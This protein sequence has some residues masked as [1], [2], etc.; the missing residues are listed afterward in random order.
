M[1]SLIEAIKNRMIFCDGGM[2]TL[3]QQ[4]GLTAGEQ[5]E[6]WNIDNRQSI[7]NIH[8]DYLKAGA[9]IITTDTFGANRLKFPD[10]G[11]YSVENVVAA[12]VGN[13]R[14]A[15]EAFGAS[16][17]YVALDIGPTGKLL[18]PAGDLDFEEA[19][20]VFAQ[21]VRQ[22][23]KSGV[24]LILIETMSDSLEARAAVLAAK[25]SCDLPVF[26]SLIFGENGKLLTGGSPASAIT[27]LEALGV[28]AVGMNCGTGPE[29]MKA[30]LPELLA[31]ATVPVIVNPN[32]GI[33]HT[34]NGKTVFDVTPDKFSVVMREIAEMG[35]NIIGG[36]CGTTPEHI[37]E[38]VKLCKSIT[39]K[40][41]ARHIKSVISSST[42]V[43]E[44]GE[45]PIIIG[46]R[47]N[48][49]GK[50]KFKQALRDN[51]VEYIF[52]EAIRQRDS[53]ADVLD[54]NVGLP[55]I[56]EPKMM[57]TI[58]SQLQAI[59]DLPLQIDT[60]DA[61]AMEKALRVYN[62]KAIINSVNGKAESLRTVLPLVKKYGG[63]A[64]ALLLDENGIPDTAEGRME[65]ARRILRAAEEN[66]IDRRD[67][68]FDALTLTIS[69]D[70]KGAL[71]TLETVGRIKNELGCHTVLGVSNVSFGLPQREIINSTFFALALQRG[72]S[73]AIIN[74]L[75]S[76]MMN[77]YRSYM[78]L[79]AM[80][81]GCKQYIDYAS[82][83]ASITQTVGAKAEASQPVADGLESAII[84]GM[85]ESAV[86]EAKALLADKSPM[87]IVN[88]QLIP[89]LDKV[90]KAFEKGTVF[91]PQLLMSAEA[92]KAAFEV[93][94]ES[95]AVS[96]AA[97]KKSGKIILATVEGDIHDIGK[98]IVKVLLESYNFD[99]I[100]LGRDVPPK[101][102]ADKAKELNVPIVGLSALMTTTVPSMEATIK[103]LR[104]TVPDCKVCV[105]GAVLTQEYADMIGADCYCPDAMA[106][107][108]FAQSLI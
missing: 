15:V 46:E 103:L 49:T 27:M 36:C 45:K 53:G 58:V 65:I 37:A 54:V 100:D 64:V 66:G 30:L 42:S 41:P 74:P 97:H 84:N 68:L 35:A 75:S 70:E 83:I 72:L 52:N 73:A 95:I 96:G 21:V 34:V 69:S 31:V 12:A 92:A 61:V 44:I 1:N 5:P 86:S 99:V 39:P 3:L 85:K 29:Q 13:A 105:G 93:I 81:S 17:K 91:L 47:I 8:S 78:A 88:G 9:D 19:V 18:K 40:A 104:Q 14:A 79:N 77:T 16:D 11:K 101:L 48:P 62:G 98:N 6:K 7:I 57:E 32:A 56:D 102:I 20:D 55:E 59:V 90:G 108:S 107:V 71:T 67:I 10:S 24:D 26:A 50:P 89:S 2:G 43:V 51:N 25:E 87:D 33:P 76:A 23:V 60:S 82:A 28:D 4:L 63:V 22:G 106:T 94:K 80:D 38:T